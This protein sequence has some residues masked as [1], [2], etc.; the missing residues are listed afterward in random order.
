M[1]QS[2]D[3]A[4]SDSDEREFSTPQPTSNN[5]AYNDGNQGG[6]AETS[7]GWAEDTSAGWA[8]AEDSSPP[9]QAEQVEA[10]A[11]EHND[12]E[13]AK[14][15]TQAAEYAQESNEPPQFA[16]EYAQEYNQ[17]ANYDGTPAA[18]G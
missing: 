10:S 5:N 6:W 2:H 14:D 1:S 9:T 11:D 12:S 18:D 13:V 17:E 16:E 8:P 4:D 7:G 3:Y 15:E